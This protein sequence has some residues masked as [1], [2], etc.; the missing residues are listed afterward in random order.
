MI[1][2][3]NGI[4]DAISFDNFDVFI[5]S[6]KEEYLLDYLDKLNYSQSQRYFNGDEVRINSSTD[7]YSEFHKM[8][9]HFYSQINLNDTNHLIHDRIDDLLMKLL[10]HIENH[11]KIEQFSISRKRDVGLKRAIEIINHRLDENISIGELCC[12]VGLSV[13]TLEYAFKEKYQSSPKES[14][15][16]IKLNKIKNELSRSEGQK[17]STM[18][19]NTDFGIWINS[20]QI[21]ENNLGSYL[22][23]F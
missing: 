23:S 14:I 22:Q 9:E 16:A 18:P 20:L 17:I 13:R 8:A 21:L 4:L 1:F 10:G 2:P 12:S 15:N 5:I 11:D 3:K 6:V 19:R 7:F